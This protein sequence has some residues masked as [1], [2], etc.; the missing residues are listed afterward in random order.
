MGR[1]SAWPLD[2]GG[3]LRQSAAAKRLLQGVDANGARH[4]GSAVQGPVGGRQ[5]LEACDRE[6]GARG[7]LQAQEIEPDLR[8]HLKNFS[9]FRIH[10]K[11]KQT[12]TDIKQI[13]TL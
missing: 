9:S 4:E 13:K 1:E 2:V 5:E 7:R 12:N 3:A 6:E 8:G 10:S 11:Q